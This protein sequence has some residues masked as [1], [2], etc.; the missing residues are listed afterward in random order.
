MLVV[1][2]TAPGRGVMTGGLAGEG[3]PGVTVTPGVLGVLGVGGVTGVL[4]VLGVT[5]VAGEIGVVV[6]AS[7]PAS[8]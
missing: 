4:G 2:S 7:V 8:L 1:I 5:G 3:V 6:S